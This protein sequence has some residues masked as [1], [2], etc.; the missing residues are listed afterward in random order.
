MNYEKP[1]K[2]A[3]IMNAPAVVVHGS[4]RTIYGLLCS[5]RL[6]ISIEK[7][8]AENLSG[9]ATDK[10]GKNYGKKPNNF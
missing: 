8:K 10:N 9:L 7:Q 1:E 3:G 2:H 5:M 4:L 6:D